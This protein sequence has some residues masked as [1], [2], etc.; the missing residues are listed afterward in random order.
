MPT[1]SAGI[2]YLVTRHRPTLD[3]AHASIL[4]DLLARA[5]ERRTLVWQ[6]AGR[7]GPS[8]AAETT[9]QLPAPAPV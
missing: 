8:T 3:S 7:R 9:S 2:G 5:V 4:F 6:T 1:A